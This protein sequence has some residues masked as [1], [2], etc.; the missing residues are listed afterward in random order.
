[1][2]AA[3]NVS[4]SVMETAREGGAWQI[5]L[6]ASMLHKE[7]NESL[8]AFPSNKVFAA[9]KSTTIAPDPGGC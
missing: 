2:A 4:V 7:E 3:M 8:E 1:M 9:G 5:A 6:L